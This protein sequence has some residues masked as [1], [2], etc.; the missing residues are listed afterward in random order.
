MILRQKI[1]AIFLLAAFVL[2]SI[3]SAQTVEQ[4]QA[5]IMALLAQ[6]RI[7][8]QELLAIQSGSG[9]WCHTFNVNLKIG[10]GGFEVRS[11]QIALQKEGLKISTTDTFDDQTASAVSGFQQKY[12]SDILTPN[13]LQYGTGYV[14]VATRTKLN[15]LY[16]CEFTNPIF[17]PP[18][19]SA[20]TSTTSSATINYLNA[21]PSIIASGKTTTLNFSATGNGLSQL[22][23][24]LTCAS[25]VATPLGEC[26]TPPT[27]AP[28][29]NGYGLEVVNTTNVN[30]EMGVMLV[31]YDAS[32]NAIVS[33]S[34]TIT[35]TPAPQEASFAASKTS[36]NS[37][38]SVTFSWNAPP[39][40][41]GMSTSFTIGCVAGITMYDVSRN[42]AFSCGDVDRSISP[43]G[44][45]TVQFTNSTNA[46]IQVTAQLDYG[47]NM[48][49]TVTVTIN[50]GTPLSSAPLT[51]TVTHSA[52][53]SSGNLSV[54]STTSMMLLDSFNVSAPN[55]GFT[56]NSITINTSPDVATGRLAISNL[57]TYTTLV[58]S[59][60]AGYF[61]QSQATIFPQT[62]YTYNG[63]F[64]APA[65]GI[66][67]VG[68]YGDTTSAASGTYAA[69]FSF[70]GATGVS[71]SGNA[72]IS[73]SGNIPGQTVTVVGSH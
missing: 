70:V 9:Q 35:I 8:Q 25:G 50:A 57:K 20:P 32:G 71:A 45:Y 22:K 64:S 17:L 19:P 41:S 33:R 54:P 67:N 21:L 51:F 68:L 43:S 72:P 61:G 27:F 16:G 31:G 39:P 65:G 59:S 42:Q 62:A 3:S 23:L 37:G 26:S 66:I 49:L 63:S 38:D 48:P 58:N 7:L 56:L 55:A 69:P 29:T 11:L 10:M 60:S 34:T 28:N 36:I 15:L 2:P 1:A 73:F 6:L 53:V 5:Q 46:A 24:I 44:S 18:S 12:A 52:T 30:Q 14:G 47:G 4:L 13:G 40:S